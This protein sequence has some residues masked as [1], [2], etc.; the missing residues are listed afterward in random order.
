MFDFS[1]FNAILFLQ[2]GSQSLTVKLK[3]LPKLIGILT[4]ENDLR[5]KLLGIV[6]NGIMFGT[7]TED[8]FVKI[9]ASLE[10]QGQ[11]QPSE[12]KLP[13]LVDSKTA[14]AELHCNKHRLNDYLNRGYLKRVKFGHRKIMVEYDSLRNFMK[15][16]IAVGGGEA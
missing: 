7:F 16:G 8:E 10:A 13:R 12:Q 5:E 14:M 9:K 11:L 15:N 2:L 4:M 6:K 1:F 3:L